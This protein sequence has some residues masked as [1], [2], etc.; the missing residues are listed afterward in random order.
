M[1]S[2]LH[3]NSGQRGEGQLGSI[4]VLIGLIALA[5]VAANMGPIWWDNYH[6][7]DSL[8]ALSQRFPPNEDGNKR[9]RAALKKTI[10]DAGLG[11]YLD[12]EDCTVTSQG[13]IGGLRTIS[14]TY[15]REYKIFGSRKSKTFDVSVSTPMF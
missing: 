4:A 11:A 12:P 14:C 7:E 3:P 6:F 1:K 2:S 10:E 9:A 8:T 15:T 13:A 5:M